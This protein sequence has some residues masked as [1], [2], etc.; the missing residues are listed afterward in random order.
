MT[1]L[2]SDVPAVPPSHWRE[3]CK[4]VGKY[5]ESLSGNQMRLTDTKTFVQ[6]CAIGGTCEIQVFS[7]LGHD[8]SLREGEEFGKYYFSTL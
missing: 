6:E 3:R 4:D 5:Y 8:A 7:S 1:W 2:G